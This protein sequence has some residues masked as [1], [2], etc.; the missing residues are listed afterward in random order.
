MYIWIALGIIWFIQIIAG[1]ATYIT[2]SRD[3]KIFWGLTYKESYKTIIKNHI[4]FGKEAY[5]WGTTFTKILVTPF[6]IVNAILEMLFY[7]IFHSLGKLFN[8]IGDTAIAVFLFIFKKHDK[9]Y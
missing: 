6:I 5:N 8:I 7:T 9:P 3:Y 4:K 2:D 1:F